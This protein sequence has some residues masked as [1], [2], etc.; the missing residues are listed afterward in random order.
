MAAL[1]GPSFAQDAPPTGLEEARQ[2][3]LDGK[4][5]AAMELLEP[6]L[7]REPDNAGAWLLLGQVRLRS[8]SYSAAMPA[9]EKARSFP[10]TRARALRAA[11][12]A[13]AG[14]GDF[15]KAAKLW[16]EMAKDAPTDLSGLHLQPEFQRLSADP[17]FTS[18]FPISF[19][20]PFLEDERTIHDWHGEGPG[21]E[22]G[23]EARNIGDVDGDGVADAVA[24]A[25][26]NQ[27]GADASGFVYVY[28][29]KTGRLLWIHKGESGNQLGLGIEAAGDV[30]GDAV[31]DVIVGAPGAG[32]AY[33]FS[34][35]DG[36]MI[37]TLN[38][39]EGDANTFG[40]SVA[41]TG[42]VDGDGR[43]DLL[44]GASGAASGAGRAYLFSS[45]NGSRLHTWEGEEQGD[46]LGSSVA[47]GG[48][49]RDSVVLVGA[50][51]AG[52]ENRGRVYVYRGK[53]A[54]P[55]FLFE[56]DET[57]GA[58]GAMFI[59]VVG[60]VDADGVPDLYASDWANQAKGPL[61]GRVYVYSGRTGGSLLTLTGEHAG[62]GFGIGPA[63]AGDVNGDGHDDLVVGAWQYRQAAPSG[64][65]VYVFS[66]KDGS[67]LESISG[68]IGGETLGFD[69]D[70]LGDVDGDGKHDYLVTSAWSLVR[71]IRSGRTLVISG[72]VPRQETN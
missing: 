61:T 9:L 7:K 10:P 64:G 32:S 18:L 40:A 62:D 51:G 23:W 54:D 44:V 49:P 27:P 1:G 4:P 60:D 57:G 68:R 15:D 72:S 55:R 13:S 70:G 16:A 46:A 38:G 29:G 28:S 34:G 59:S 50:P 11:L 12:L 25:P 67:L 52:P 8:Q 69:A 47:G 43:P 39:D 31:P 24:S 63:R 17:R 41:S 66:G 21:Q 19:G 36:A 45:A 3:A 22:F 48:F 33:V 71:G 42:D 56:A 35:R 26:G 30:N 14:L 58:L 37:L 53:S 65:K 2:Y 6:L 20:D 5:A